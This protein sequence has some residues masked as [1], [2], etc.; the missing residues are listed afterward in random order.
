MKNVRGGLNRVA[1]VLC[2]LC[3]TINPADFT[4][5][6]LHHVHLTTLQRLGYLR[7]GGGGV[8]HVCCNLELAENLFDAV[9]REAFVFYEHP[10]NLL[11][12]KRVFI[13]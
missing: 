2:E 9:Q 8:E 5:E 7:G 3:E 4:A 6:L 12:R 11:N 1:T 10:L 13:R